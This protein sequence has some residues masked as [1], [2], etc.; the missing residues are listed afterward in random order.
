MRALALLMAIAAATPAFAQQEAGQDAGS[1]IVVTGKS[2]SDTEKQLK[3]CLAR[4]CPPMEDMEASMG[5]AENQLLAGDYLGS[6]DTLAAAHD[7]NVSHAKEFP[8]EFSDLERAFGRVT[9]LNG[10]PESGKLHQ[11][12]SFETLKQGF[13]DA[14]SRALMQQLAT[15][16]AFA[17][18]G[19]IRAAT[20]IYREVAKRARAEG[21][22]QLA[23][24]AMFREAVLYTSISTVDFTYRDTARDAIRAILKTREPELEETRVAAGV[25]QARLAKERGDDAAMEREIAKLAGKG[26]KTP[27]LVYD[28]PLYRDPPPVGRFKRDLQSNPE[29]VDIR[30]R[31]DASGHVRDV[32]QIRQSPEL[33]IAWADRIREVIGRR[34]YVPLD[35]PPGSEGLTRIER[36][37]MV[38]DM[39]GVVTG[40]HMPTRKA[41]PRF[42]SLD[43]TP[44]PPAGSSD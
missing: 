12:V 36:Y 1:A 16:D 31:I 22:P 37:T 8:L 26:F 9:D 39:A 35:L 23:G 33:T 7:R 20:D 30:F 4:H 24:I 34:R 15:G 27:V 5:H 43:I 3:D 18:G 13:G 6:R 21:K 29:W 41:T 17:Q 11:I 2:L 32:E 42:T 28:E 38:F 14:D 40:T 19:R 44:E 25:L 10:K